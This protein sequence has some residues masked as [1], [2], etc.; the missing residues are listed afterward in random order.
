A[1]P[2]RLKV[3]TTTVQSGSTSGGTDLVRRFIRTP[4]NSFVASC[5]RS[6]PRQFCPPMRPVARRVP[7]APIRRR[8]PAHLYGRHRAGTHGQGTT[9]Y[10]NMVEN[11]FLMPAEGM[12]GGDRPPPASRGE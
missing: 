4:R 6:A 5:S 2:S 10:D 11:N 7:G 12:G 8:V 9:V 1:S 3:R